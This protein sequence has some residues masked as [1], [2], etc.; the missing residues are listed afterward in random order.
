MMK[1]RGANRRWL[2]PAFQARSP[3]IVSEQAFIFNQLATEQR[4]FCALAR[5]LHQSG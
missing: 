4:F 2:N 3:A 1:Q 5:F